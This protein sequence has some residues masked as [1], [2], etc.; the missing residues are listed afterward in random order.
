MPSIKICFA[1]QRLSADEVKVVFG[2]LVDTLKTPSSW[3]NKQ[4][5]TAT[6]ASLIYSKNTQVLNMKI[7]VQ[8][9][10]KKSSSSLYGF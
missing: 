6:G 1:Q 8:N 9:E 2:T 4:V 3:E 5:V 10:G 7:T